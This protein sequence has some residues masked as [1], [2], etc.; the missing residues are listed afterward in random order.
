[1]IYENH[2]KGAYSVENGVN[3]LK[4]T[5]ISCYNMKE[6]T[7]SL[8]D[9]LPREGTRESYVENISSFGIEK[10][11][12]I[13]ERLVSIGALRI[14]IKTPLFKKITG[15]LIKPD[16]MLFPAKW[17][18]KLLE[19]VGITLSRRWLLSNLKIF[20]LLS[21]S[22]IAIS[23]LLS[24]SGIYPWLA[25]MS[26][27]HPET[28]HMFALVLFGSLVH[29]LGHSLTAAACGIGLRPIG[30]SVYLFYPVFYT[31]VS[32]IDKLSTQ[33]KAAIDCG[34]FFSQSA[35][36]FLLLL[37]WLFT[38]NLLFLESLRWISVIMVFNMNPCLRTD[39][40]WLY[41]DVRKGLQINKVT[42]FFHYLYIVAFAAFSVY[43]LSYVY[44]RSEYIYGLVHAAY[45]DPKLLLHEGHKILLGCYLIVMFFVGSV[46]RFHETRKEWLELKN[47]RSNGSGHR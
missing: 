39:G 31:N 30:F 2:L 47:T 24:F 34:G 17:Q 35:Y 28:V 40:Y 27:G 29:E 37:S 21:A 14:K 12:A 10:A 4:I 15:N 45:L 23:L 20:F 5:A 41:K 33:E 1:M 25:G 7:L 22:G 3:S 19:K 36:L 38:K 16:I 43:L 13:F 26:T 18:E 8:I 44:A 42:E 6:E 46:S 9:L 11:P 32:G